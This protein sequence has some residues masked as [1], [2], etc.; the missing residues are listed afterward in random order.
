[1]SE[2]AYTARLKEIADKC[3]LFKDEEEYNQVNNDNSNSINMVAASIF[4]REEF[5]F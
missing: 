3:P 2:I 4:E 5:Q 1:M